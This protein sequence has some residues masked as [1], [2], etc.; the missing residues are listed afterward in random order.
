MTAAT[1]GNFEWTQDWFTERYHQRMSSN[2][3]EFLSRA[4]G[5]V[6]GACASPPL[7]AVLA[8]QAG[9]AR[10]D[11]PWL[12]EVLAPPAEASGPSRP[13]RSAIITVTDHW[14]SDIM[15]AEGIGK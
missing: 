6:V 15:V 8:A 5:A 10:R 13:L 14:E 4:A 12:H 3:R 2:R 11:V 1:A 7:A 9:S